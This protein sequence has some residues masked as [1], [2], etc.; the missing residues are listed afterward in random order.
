M[1]HINKI[2]ES[3]DFDFN[4]E[5]IRDIFTDF[6]D[7]GFKVYVRFG[8]RLHQFHEIDSKVTNQEI[9]LGFRLSIWVHLMY[10]ENSLR[11][12]MRSD[13]YLDLLNNVQFRLSQEK[14]YIEGIDVSGNQI[15][16]LIYTK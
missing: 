9:K 3:Q 11:K 13:K 7:E 8:K 4:E 2:F 5:D 1:R 12:F 10:S 6:E 14:L 16:L 15:N